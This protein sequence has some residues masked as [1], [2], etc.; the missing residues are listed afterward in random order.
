MITTDNESLIEQLE[1]IMNDNKAQI[2][3]V[4]DSYDS[5]NQHFIKL[6][7]DVNQIM[8]QIGVKYD[9][10]HLSNTLRTQQQQ[11]ADLKTQLQSL[12]LE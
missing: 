10:D 4:S 9:Q 12:K 11:L 7:T 5:L 8:G 1:T 2:D 3:G 6:Q